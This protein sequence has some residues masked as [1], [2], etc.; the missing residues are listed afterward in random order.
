MPLLFGLDNTT[1]NLK[2]TTVSSGLLFGLGGTPGQ[3]APTPAPLSYTEQI[4]KNLIENNAPN[5]PQA[6]DTSIDTLL[7]QSA[8]IETTNPK[9]LASPDISTVSQRLSVPI[10][11]L[12]WYMQPGRAANDVIVNAQKDLSSRFQQ[13]SDS[14][15]PDGTLE[16]GTLTSKQ[17]AADRVAK[18]GS[19]GLGIINAGLSPFTALF[20]GGEKLPVIGDVFKAANGFI[21]GIGDLGNHIG[22]EV[23]NKLPV[24]DATKDNLRPVIG[25]IFSLT[26]QFGLGAIT[27]EVVKSELESLSKKTSAI[28]ADDPKVKLSVK[29]ET[30]EEAPVKVNTPTTKH[31]EY[32]A[33]QGYEGYKPPAELPTIEMGTKPKST[34]PVIQTEAPPIS[35][36]PGLHYEEVSPVEI[37]KLIDDS[38][39][40]KST[41]PEKSVSF[42]KDN[43]ADI[44]QIPIRIK[45]VDGNLT[46]ENGRNRLTAAKELGISNIKVEDTTPNGSKILQS[47]S[48]KA[49]EG[50]G[51]TNVRGLSAGVEASAIEKKLTSGFGDLPEYQKMNMKEQAQMATE[52]M[53]EN[54]DHAKKVALGEEKPPEGLHPEAVFTAVEERALKDG[55]V[56][57]LRDLA[58]RSTLTS[59]ATTMGQRIKLLDERNPESPVKAIRDVTKAREKVASKDI[60]G[61]VKE[62][63]AEIDKA[64]PTKQSWTDF[65]KEIQCK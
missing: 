50:T 6:P 42:Y 51:A 62:I 45:E 7:K 10:E 27:H 39:S 44:T 14:L 37:S 25:E 38:L 3:S 9:N 59:E 43:P 58:T 8:A 55:D 47:I 52:L 24:S 64:K 40:E 65:I 33:S 31:A 57:T 41:I 18:A 19:L 63:K 11:T 22:Q 15:Q 20:K 49:I 1:Q 28:I 5:T 21:G 17:L 61:T 16:T 60:K 34:L 12:P 23:T 2:P 30:P 36:P 53:K 4:T 56:A 13:L 48:P 46:V 29:S 26:S 32:A 54:Y 35:A